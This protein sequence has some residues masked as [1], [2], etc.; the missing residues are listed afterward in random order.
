MHRGEMSAQ[1]PFGGALPLSA[2]F[3]KAWIDQ[4]GAFQ[5]MFTRLAEQSSAAMP[6]SMLSPLLAP[7]KDFVDRMG[8]GG[9][10]PAQMFPGAPA[11]GSTS[12][13]RQSPSIT[14]GAAGIMANPGEDSMAGRPSVCT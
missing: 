8:T 11:L 9:F 3:M 7:W 6:A 13:H 5:E 2:G 10:D 14:P 1:G 4:A 12:A